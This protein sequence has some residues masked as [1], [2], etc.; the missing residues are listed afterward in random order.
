[1]S[2]AMARRIATDG[3]G[4]RLGDGGADAGAGEP[5]LVSVPGDSEGDS[6]GATDG[7]GV[8]R[9]GSRWPLALAVA[10]GAVGAVEGTVGIVGVGSGVADCVS[11]AG[12]RS[13]RSTRT[14][15]LPPDPS[16]VIIT[17]C[18]SLGDPMM[19]FGSE[20][21]DIRC[22]SACRSAGQFDV[23]SAGQTSSMAALL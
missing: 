16:S 8:P 18:P 9:Q 1:M 19:V 14:T 13:G 11:G 15:S 6:E 17:A 7:G 12:V 2:L 23:P 21:R 5:A 22:W 20:S 3:D 4:E 10:G